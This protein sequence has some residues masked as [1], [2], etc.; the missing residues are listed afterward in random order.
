MVQLLLSLDLHTQI[1]SYA[2]PSAGL[3]A[4][5]EWA[6]GSLEPSAILTG[7]V[8]FEIANDWEERWD[9]RFV[10]TYYM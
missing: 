3:F 7:D 1:V 6:E 9:V 10:Y 2:T 5:S 4:L 8:T